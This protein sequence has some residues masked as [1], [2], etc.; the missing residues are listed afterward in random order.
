MSASS[1]DL[2]ESPTTAAATTTTALSRYGKLRT[3]GTSGDHPADALLENNDSAA[4]KVCNGLLFS[5]DESILNCESSSMAPQRQLNGSSA[6]EDRDKTPTAELASPPL[7]GE[8][9]AMQSTISRL[10]NKY[11]DILNKIA[12][13]KRE[14]NGDVDLTTEALKP[15]SLGTSAS[16]RLAGKS[17]VE[18]EDRE[19]TLEADSST[20]TA[21][22]SSFIDRH[23]KED[24]VGSSGF[25]GLSKSA[26]VIHIPPQTKKSD[27]IPKTE[28]KYV[29]DKEEKKAKN[30]TTTT[31]A[32]EYK[33]RSDLFGTS[34]DI[35]SYL[36]RYKARNE[37]DVS[38]RYKDTSELIES[39]KTGPTKSHY[40]HYG[41]YDAGTGTDSVSPY[42]KSRYDPE[43]YGGVEK[44]TTSSSSSAAARRTKSYRTRKESSKER[45]NMTLKLS[46]VNMDIDSPPPTT[47]SSITA[48]SRPSAIA[49]SSSA[50]ASSSRAYKQYGAAR[51]TGPS[52]GSYQRSQT[53]KLLY[54]FDDNDIY[55]PPTARDTQRKDIQN[56]IR[57]YAQYDDEDLRRS[58]KNPYSTNPL[59]SSATSGNLS[60]LSGGGASGS[61]SHL[62]ADRRD[63]I[64]DHYAL[65]SA[66]GSYYPRC[67][68][69][70]DYPGYGSSVLGKANPYSSSGLSGSSSGTSGMHPYGLSKT[71]TSA[72]LYNPSY[73]GSSAASSS[74]AAQQRSRKNLMSFVR[75][76]VV[77]VFV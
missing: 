76:C 21:L 10:E 18:R 46:A 68:Y 58:S 47:S 19:K 51:K 43:S 25:A 29:V 69:G 7:T 12:R 73:L 74:T 53:Q 2:N 63:P 4:A 35:D 60:Y 64:A 48:A 77:G 30:G 42:Y 41:H 49:P 72:A 71:Q 67:H 62:Y 70:Y 26:T 6:G 11:A 65:G 34:G 33:P 39:L 66:S 9:A 44:P 54:D 23:K 13:R 24:S 22:K 15:T 5:C 56:V 3:M 17:L 61:G 45:K 38:N 75:G 27:A 32:G 1:V 14:Q 52:T 8:S 20:T 55:H 57:K 36:S 37:R 50:A 31:T 59:K 40:N 16:S 28:A